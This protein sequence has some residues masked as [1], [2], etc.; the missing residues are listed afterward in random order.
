MM[1]VP[2]LVKQQPGFVNAELGS[3]ST[4]RGLLH[5]LPSSL[6]IAVESG[7]RLPKC[8][9]HFGSYL[10]AFHTS[11]RSPV[12]GILISSGVDSGASTLSGDDL[13]HVLPPSVEWAWYTEPICVRM[14]ISSR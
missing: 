10:A 2:L 8:D 14:T 13:P 12:D 3:V 7:V 11:S 4:C 9:F 6:E 1:T 5:V